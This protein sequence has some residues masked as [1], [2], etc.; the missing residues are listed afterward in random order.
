MAAAREE[1]PPGVQRGRLQGEHDEVLLLEAQPA[2]ARRDV[3][4]RRPAQDSPLDGVGPAG[5]LS[6]QTWP[7]SVVG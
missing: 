6:R 2:H 5:A 7:E 3:V 4:R 1:L